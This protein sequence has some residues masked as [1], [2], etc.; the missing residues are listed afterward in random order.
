VKLLRKDLVATLLY[1][2]GAVLYAAYESGT[3]L[4]FIDTPRRVAGVCLALALAACTVWGVGRGHGR[5]ATLEGSLMVA[6]AAL[7]VTALALAHTGAVEIL[8]AGFV[9]VL[10][11]LWM[12][13]L[14]DHDGTSQGRSRGV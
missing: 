9:A 6:A 1:A 5:L 13:E 3:A 12:V 14:T 2:V 8:L 10:L 7:G 4:P 11:A